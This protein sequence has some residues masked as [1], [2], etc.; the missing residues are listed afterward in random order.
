M[1]LYYK[2]MNNAPHLAVVASEAMHAIEKVSDGSN[3]KLI[4]RVTVG[5]DSRVF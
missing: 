4:L 1:L 2:A 3:A 5:K